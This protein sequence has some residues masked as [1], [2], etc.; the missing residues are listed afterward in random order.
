M[1]APR[2]RPRRPLPRDAAQPLRRRRALCVCPPLLLALPAR[3]A[4]AAAVCDGL[5]VADGARRRGA[6]RFSRPV[7][8]RR[9]A[10]WRQRGRRRPARR[11]GPRRAARLDARQ[12]RRP[13]HPR[14]HQGRHQADLVRRASDHGDVLGASRRR[15]GRRLRGEL[16]A[17]VRHAARGKT[18]A[19]RL[20]HRPP[21]AGA[22]AARP[23][24]PPRAP[25]P[26]GP[27]R[28]RRVRRLPRPPAAEA[29][30]AHHHPRQ[31]A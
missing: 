21:H 16:A 8:R 17:G 1:P 31:A 28:R 9:P 19:A 30:S 7:H 29:L 14:R 26:R 2:L 24:W 13:H 23:H 25:A 10:H 3:G 5:R 12:G 4:P 11:R 27:R 6:S 20:V 18:R 15:R 22:T